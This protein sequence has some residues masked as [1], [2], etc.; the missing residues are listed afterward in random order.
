MVMFVFQY[1]A[2]NVFDFAKLLDECFDGITVLDL[3]AWE[4][5]IWTLEIV[6]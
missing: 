4:I 2:P 5:G 6:D 1:L 3:V